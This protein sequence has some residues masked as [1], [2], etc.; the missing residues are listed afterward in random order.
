MD[1]FIES[2]KLK[3][4]QIKYPFGAFF[5]WVTTALGAIGGLSELISSISSNSSIREWVL[6]LTLSCITLTAVSALALREF[7]RLKR[8]RFA[9][10]LPTLIESSELLRDLRSFLNMH[11]ATLRRSE[12]VPADVTPRAREMIGD[13][14]TKQA[15]MFSTMTATHCRTCV[16]LIDVADPG[17][18]EILSPSDIYVFTLA[19]DQQSAK[20]NRTHDATR[21]NKRLDRLNFNSDFLSLW[22]EKVDDHGYFHSID[23]RKEKDY[24]TSSL[25]Y[26]KNIAGS[27]YQ[28]SDSNW[29]LSYVSTIVWPI[30]QDPKN[31]LG[32]TDFRTLGFLAVDSPQQGAFDK[33]IHVQFGAILGSGLI[34]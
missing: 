22:D 6:S 15:N 32:I 20:G 29:P 17:N 12:A 25:H 18:Q 3:I 8:M 19:R 34:D 21:A 11:V 13:L 33:D 26:W 10:C 30:R 7:A 28:K 27:A 24:Q 23:L 5:A 2:A 31:S 4:A 1:G 14:L 16:K 9:R